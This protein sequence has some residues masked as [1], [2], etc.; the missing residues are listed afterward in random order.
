MRLNKSIALPAVVLLLLSAMMVV[1]AWEAD[2]DEP[3]PSEVNFRVSC[4]N[5]SQRQFNH[6]TS[7]LHSLRYSHSENAYNAIARHE[8]ECAMAFWGIAMS[9]LK[10]PIA[11]PPSVEDVRSANAALE[12]S[13]AAEVASPRERAYIGALTTLVED[14]ALATWPQRTLAYEQAME[15]IVRQYSDD[16]EAVIFYALALNMAAPASDRTYAKQTKAAEL[17]LVALS[18]EPNHPGITHYLT[19]CLNNISS[20]TRDTTPPQG[21]GMKSG[22]RLVLLGGLG[23]LLAFGLCSLAL[24]APGWTQNASAPI[25]GPFTLVA[26][27]GRTVS[28]RDLRGKWVLIYFGYTH[29]PDVCPT[30]LLEIA[31][32]LGE[33]GPLAADVQPVFITID[34]ERDTPESV[35]EFAAAFDPRIIGL[36]GTPA[37]IASVAKKYRVYYKKDARPGMKSEDYLMEHSAFVYLMGPTGAYVNL[38]SP[39]RGQG[40]DHMAARLRD[41]IGSDPARPMQLVA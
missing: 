5:S 39:R 14:G 2:P 30:T 22:T 16:R 40:P 25:G 3:L 26:A 21:T 4:S 32:T 9:R 24:L 23:A 11:A 34:P 6:A 13:T 7:L 35:A 41:L 1:L 36:S 20:T 15:A 18:E 33:L 37:Q 8:P 38:F 10:R 28:D 27:N 12:R 29:C 31:Q 17:L 19:Y